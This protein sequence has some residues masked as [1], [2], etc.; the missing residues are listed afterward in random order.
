MGL[1]A[2]DIQPLQN[3]PILHRFQD[4]PEEK[5]KWVEQF[6]GKGLEAIETMLQETAGTY[7]YGDSITLADACIIPQCHSARR[8]NIDMNRFPTILRVE[9]AANA[10]TSFKNASYQSQPDCPEELR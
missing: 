2:A 4:Q 3:L 5:A 6:V 1:I 7:A 8:F 9:A 10:L